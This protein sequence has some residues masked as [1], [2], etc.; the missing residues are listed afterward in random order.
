MR[1]SDGLGKCVGCLVEGEKVE[2]VM[3][4]KEL[5]VRSRERFETERVP[6]RG[7]D[8]DDY[9]GARFA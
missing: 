3:K 7:W 5:R 8:D 6:P 1:E 2:I 9:P 4:Q